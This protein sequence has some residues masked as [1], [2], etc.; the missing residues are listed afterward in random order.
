MNR[1][2]HELI[3]MKARKVEIELE[4]GTSQIDVRHLSSQQIQQIDRDIEHHYNPAVVLEMINKT[5]KY[6]E[7]LIKSRH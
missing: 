6:D 7:N 1:T 3:N 2:I 4:L 5:I